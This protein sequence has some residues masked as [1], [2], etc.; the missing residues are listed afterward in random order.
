MPSRPQRQDL[1]LGHPQ[2]GAGRRVGGQDA[3][4]VGVGEDD[5][6][7]VQFVHDPEHGQPVVVFEVVLGHLHLPSD[8]KMT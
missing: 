7:G 5:A 3:A 1:L 4:L 8:S 2:D 6:L